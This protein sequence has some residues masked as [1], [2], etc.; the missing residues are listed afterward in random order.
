VGIV[1]TL[2]IDG[3][4]FFQRALQNLRGAAVF[5][6]WASVK[7]ALYEAVTGMITAVLA[8]VSVRYKITRI[9]FC[10]DN[11]RNRSLRRI[12]LSARRRVNK[13]LALVR[14]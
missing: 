12:D 14:G 11:H 9:V 5:R 13:I 10:Y 2:V 8:E 7:T 4:L 3:S 6:P 1:A